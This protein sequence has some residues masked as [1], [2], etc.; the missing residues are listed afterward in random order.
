MPVPLVAFAASSVQSPPKYITET[1]IAAS[2]SPSRKVNL[3]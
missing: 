1:N 3:A 2:P